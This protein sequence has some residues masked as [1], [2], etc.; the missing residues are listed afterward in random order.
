MLPLTWKSQATSKT[1]LSE[2]DRTTLSPS[3]PETV[4]ET[5]SDVTE[6]PEILCGEMGAHLLLSPRMKRS[7]PPALMAGDV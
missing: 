4:T 5:P 2:K 6:T 3:T 1:S 7:L